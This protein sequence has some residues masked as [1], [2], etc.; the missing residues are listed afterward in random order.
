MGW[1]GGCTAR[2]FVRYT[3]QMP[4]DA[5]LKIKDYKSDLAVK[6]LEADLAIDTY[7]GTVNVAGLAGGFRIETYKGDVRAEIVRLM[8]DVRA[9]TYKGSIVLHLPDAAAFELSADSGRHGHFRSDFPVPVTSDSV[10]GR[11]LLVQGAVNGGGPRVTL[12]T[13]KGAVTLRKG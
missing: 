8:G 3:I 13:D 9:E 12:K 10:H 4:K 2:P 1:F 5:P 6:G 11:S 7:K